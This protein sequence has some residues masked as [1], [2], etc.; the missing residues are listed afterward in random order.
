MATLTAVL[1]GCRLPHGLTL[2]HPK[3]P[4][5]IKKRVT[6]LG[7]NSSKIIGATFI[8]TEIDSEFWK[9]W[10]TAHSDHPALANGA[11]FEA[12]TEADAKAMGKEFA[13]EKTGFEPMLQEA[14]GVSKSKE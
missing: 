10:K 3:Y 1:I 14:L 8:T 5:D 9:L 4:R 13:S 11:I 6:I 2:N 7:M 12:D